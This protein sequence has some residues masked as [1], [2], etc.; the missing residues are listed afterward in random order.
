MEIC[1]ELPEV[2][3]SLNSYAISLF[4]ILAEY[5]KHNMNSK[6]SFSATHR[7]NDRQLW[8]E[9]RRVDACR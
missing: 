1:A 5:I 6:R 4:S 2:I 8:Q 9:R 3:K 7:S